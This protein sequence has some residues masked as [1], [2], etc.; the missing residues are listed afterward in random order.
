[1]MHFV[2]VPVE[3]F[4][5]ARVLRMSGLCSRGGGAC[6]T[7]HSRAGSRPG[8]MMRGSRSRSRTVSAH[9]GRTRGKTKIGS[10]ATAAGGNGRA[11]L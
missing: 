5:A 9:K 8:T 2:I 4:A 10:I 6:K 11:V 1:M 7:G 3:L